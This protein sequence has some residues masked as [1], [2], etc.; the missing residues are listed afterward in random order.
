MIKIASLVLDVY[1]DEQCKI[2]RRLPP[3]LQELSVAGEEEVAELPDRLFGLVLKTASGVRRKFPLHTDDA[4]K[5]SEAYLDHVEDLLPRDAVVMARAKIAAAKDGEAYNDVAYVN[6][7]QVQPK[8]AEFTDRFYGLTV[9]D[10]SFFPLHDEALVKRAVARFPFTTDGMDPAQQFR[11]ARNIEKRASQL[12]VDIPGDSGIHRYTNDELNLSAL[13]EGIEQRKSAA[14]RAGLGTEVLDQLALASGVRID[15]GELQHPDSHALLREKQAGI[16]KL[17]ADQIVSTLMQFD[18]AAGVT[19]SDYARGLLDPFASCFKRAS[20]LGSNSTLVDGVDLSKVD[21]AELRDKFD[22]DFVREFSANPVGVYRS[23]PDPVKSV[24][25]SMAESQ[26]GQP[27]SS[28]RLRPEE[29]AVGS[30][31]DPLARLGPTFVNG[32]TS[33]AD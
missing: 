29:D 5:L 26:M 13:R 31:G 14:H 17:A 27:T 30:G 8:K 24:V 20:Y 23:L 10:R 19:Q 9:G 32:S 28:R 3:D 2:A 21:P 7:E 33:L 22:D 1:D 4:I 18:R 25:R 6:L 15:P 16:F 12:G 11:Y